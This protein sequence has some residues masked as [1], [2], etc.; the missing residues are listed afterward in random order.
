MDKSPK[1]LGGGGLTSML[2]T[3]TEY[4]FGILLGKDLLSLILG[5]KQPEL[6]EL[7]AENKPFNRKGR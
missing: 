7:L 1:I 2:A 4:A 6:K 3:R 5:E